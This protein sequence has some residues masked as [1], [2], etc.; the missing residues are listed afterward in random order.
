[1][2]VDQGGEWLGGWSMEGGGCEWAA[3]SQNISHIR[4][5]LANRNSSASRMREPQMLEGI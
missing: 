5:E 1:M 3:P 2:R 4:P